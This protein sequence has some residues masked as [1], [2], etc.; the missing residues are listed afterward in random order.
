AGRKDRATESLRLQRWSA[1][2]FAVAEEQRPRISAVTAADRRRGVG[3]SQGRWQAS[4][5]PLAVAVGVLPLQA[6]GFAI[7]AHFASAAFKI[8]SRLLVVRW[9][10]IAT[11]HNGDG[12]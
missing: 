5:L 7:P 9:Q 3:Q 11:R 10:R 6:D 8:F 12:P 4:L 2:L 1:P